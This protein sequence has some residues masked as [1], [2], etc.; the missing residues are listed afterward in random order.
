MNISSAYLLFLSLL[1]PQK[2]PSDLHLLQDNETQI[3]AQSFRNPTSAVYLWASTYR[4]RNHNLLNSDQ[5]DWKCQSCKDDNEPVFRMRQMFGE[6]QPV[7]AQYEPKLSP[8]LIE[9]PLVDVEVKLLKS[10][11]APTSDSHDEGVLSD[12]QLALTEK[13]AVPTAVMSSLD[14]YEHQQFISRADPV[15]STIYSDS[16]TKD[17]IGKIN[18]WTDVKT[19]LWSIWAR[20]LL[21]ITSLCF[22][23][24]GGACCMLIG[25]ALGAVSEWQR[26]RTRRLVDQLEQQVAAMA[27]ASDHAGVV[28]S[29]TPGLNRV[30]E[31]LGPAH[32]DSVV[33]KHHLAQAH[34]A[35]NHGAVAEALL[36]EVLAVLSSTFGENAP[37]ALCTRDLALALQQQSR[38]AESFHTLRTALRILCEE[39]LSSGHTQPLVRLHLTPWGERP[40]HWC[41]DSMH[42]EEAPATPLGCNS[43]RSTGLTPTRCLSRAFDREVDFRTALEELDGL[44][45]SDGGGQRVVYKRAANVCR[46]HRHLPLLPCNK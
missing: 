16:N 39:L 3:K 7:L 11:T 19:T 35:L 28:R 43:D 37:T 8:N 29:L 17:N 23:L 1:S 33:L 4:S 27:A 31:L 13:I 15:A 5:H 20:E 10:L 14:E 38:Y 32:L 30:V 22:F 42:R 6:V 9:W 46:S 41:K 34:L 45:V 18:E 40:R 26:G 36:R 25:S 44:L 21:T 12:N 24:M 2:R